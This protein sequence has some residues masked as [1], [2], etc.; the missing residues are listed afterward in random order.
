MFHETPSVAEST[1]VSHEVTITN[2]SYLELRHRSSRDENPR[3]LQYEPKNTKQ[4]L[5]SLAPHW[6]RVLNILQQFKYSLYLVCKPA[7]YVNY[8]TFLL[9]LR[10]A[11]INGG[12]L[13]NIASILNNLAVKNVIIKKTAKTSF[14]IKSYKYLK[15]SPTKWLETA[16]ITFNS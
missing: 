12:I 11:F 2:A 4:R 14:K 10:N 1:W 16:F 8:K 15:R 7:G 13:F 6:L 3:R 5:F 9:P